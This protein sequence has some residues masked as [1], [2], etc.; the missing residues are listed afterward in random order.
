MD[1]IVRTSA[2]I[3]AALKRRRRSLNLSQGA[4]GEKI[5]LRQATISSLETGDR[6]TR[7]STLLDAMAALG[8]ELVI[9]PRTRSRSDDS[10]DV[11]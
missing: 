7:L 1:Q 5:S 11:L 2:H 10:D 9:R 3:G 4:L 8:L 6:G